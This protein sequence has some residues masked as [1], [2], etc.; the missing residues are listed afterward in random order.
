M[1]VEV[2]DLYTVKRRNSTVSVYRKDG[3]MCV[4]K[5]YHAK[6]SVVREVES[7]EVAKT[8]LKDTSRF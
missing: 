4:K 8:V 5:K 3:R 7:Y 1:S 6:Y 2:D